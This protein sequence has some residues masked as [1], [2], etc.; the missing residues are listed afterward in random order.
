MKIVVL[1]EGYTERDIVSDLFARWLNPRVTERVG[2]KAVRFNGWKQ[3]VDDAP[4][5]AELHLRDP[6]VLGVIA[7]LDLYGPTF[8]P[9][10]KRDAASRREWGMKYL[11]DQ[12]PDPRYRP[13]FAI[14]EVE[15]W[16][17]PQPDLFDSRVAKKLPGKTPEEV[18]FNEPPAKL[19]DRLYNEALKRDYKKVV[20]GTKLFRSL[21][22]AMVYA[23]CPAF[24]ALADDLLDLCP[25]SIRK[26]PKP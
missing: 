10:D 5:K 9:P 2:F 4:M 11:K 17:L 22:P 16:L 13:H 23:K 18:N 6:K 1:C 19:L 25:A 3:L 8:Y 14:H 24:K 21:D 20:E 7:L 15:A 26:E 12:H